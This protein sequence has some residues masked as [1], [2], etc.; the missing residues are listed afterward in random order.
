MKRTGAIMLL[1]GASA[2]IGGCATATPTAPYSRPA[3]WATPVEASPGLPNLHRVNAGLYR[4]AQPSREGFALLDTY[5]SLASGDPPLKTIVSLRASKDDSSSS[6]C[7]RHCASRRYRSRPGTPRTRTSSSSCGSPRRLPCNRCCSLP[8]WLGSHGHDGGRLSD[9]RRRLDQ[10]AGHRRDDPWRLRLPP[11]VAKPTAL[12]RGAG[13]RRHSRAGL[14]TRSVAMTRSPMQ[15][16]YRHRV[17]GCRRTRTGG[18]SHEST[19]EVLAV[20][21]TL[22]LPSIAQSQAAQAQRRTPT[23]SPTAS[24]PT[25]SPTRTSPAWSS[26]SWSTGSSS[27][28]ALSACRTSTR[29]ARSRATHS[30]AWHR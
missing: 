25:S 20:A 28:S 2:L 15:P 18:N 12:H 29:S 7:P 16:R 10:G 5:V 1:L 17:A 22:A 30:S 14:G 11:R 21:L 4:S 13:R 24:S 9:R 27:T 8:A 23:R 6:P 3:S 26:A 19:L